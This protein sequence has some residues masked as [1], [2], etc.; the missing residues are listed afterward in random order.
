MNYLNDMTN[1]ELAQ[2]TKAL[3]QYTEPVEAPA[4]EQPLASEEERD[5]QNYGSVPAE[6]MNENEDATTSVVTPEQAFFQ[7][8]NAATASDAV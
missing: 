7:E 2:V 6:V 8:L 5:E 4:E 1:S 3:P